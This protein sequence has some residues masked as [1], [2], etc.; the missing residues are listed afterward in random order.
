[1]A[2]FFYYYPKIDWIF[3]P[4]IWGFVPKNLVSLKKVR[5]TK[6]STISFSTNYF[7]SLQKKFG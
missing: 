1:M 5:N 4:K 3:V 6:F 7:R 2:G